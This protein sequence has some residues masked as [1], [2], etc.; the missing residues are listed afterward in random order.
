MLILGITNPA[1]RKKYM[2]AA[3]P[4]ACGKTNLAMLLPKLPGWKIECVGDDICWM[5]VLFAALR[6]CGSGPSAFVLC[7]AC[8][9]CM[10]LPIPVT[11]G[12]AYTSHVALEF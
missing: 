7:R 3:F 2:A 1:G 4:S 6:L 8:R 11:C 5:K 10:V 9:L 12:C